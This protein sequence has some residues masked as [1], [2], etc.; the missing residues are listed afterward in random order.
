MSLVNYLKMLFRR[1]SKDIYHSLNEKE[2]KMK[3]YI[4]KWGEC[5][6]LFPDKRVLIHPEDIN[7]Y[8]ELMPYDC[9]FECVAHD[10]KYLTLMREGKKVRVKPDLFKELPQPD[11]VYGQKVRVKSKKTRK[12]I[13]GVVSEI[14]WHFK[15]SKHT[16][17]I[18]ANG[19]RKKKNYWEEDFI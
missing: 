7:D 2:V 19:K 8:D 13:E 16:Y 14:G 15:Y 6:A 3:K 18:T 9:L 17:S 1:I 10:G 4:G 12:I 5:V 11:K